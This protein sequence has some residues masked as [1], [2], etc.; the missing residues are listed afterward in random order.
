MESKPNDD[1]KR[2]VAVASRLGS[3]AFESPDAPQFAAI[4]PANKTNSSHGLQAI[5]ITHR[6]GAAQFFGCHFAMA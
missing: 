5:A 3:S 6:P 4:R 2:G 1:V